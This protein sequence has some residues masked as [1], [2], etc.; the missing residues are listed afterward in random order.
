M[1]SVERDVDVVIDDVD[2][3]AVATVVERR[4]YELDELF[5]DDELRLWEDDAGWNGF[6]REEQADGTVAYYSVNT[7][8]DEDSWVRKVRCG[9]EAVRNGIQKHIADPKAGEAGEF[10]RRC[11]P[12]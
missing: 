9:K 7:R 2:N 6:I 5:Q 10:R 8:H 11:S 4:E 3:R 12:P 1:S